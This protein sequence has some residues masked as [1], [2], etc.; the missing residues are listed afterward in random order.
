M[1]QAVRGELEVLD[2]E[3]PAGGAPVPQERHVVEEEDQLAL[4]PPAE[5]LGETGHQQLV[6]AHESVE[7]EIKEKP[8]WITGLSAPNGV[9]VSKPWFNGF[10]K[11]LASDLICAAQR[12]CILSTLAAVAIC[13]QQ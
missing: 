1:P 10:R 6:A 9:P 8:P 5:E 12:S 13:A 3:P 11:L 7:E 2:S 4:L